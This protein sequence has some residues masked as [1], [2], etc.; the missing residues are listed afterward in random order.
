MP[1]T[2]AQCRRRRRRLLA[3]LGSQYKAIDAHIA[4]EQATWTRAIKNGW[5]A[6]AL[7]AVD[8]LKVLWAI[9]DAT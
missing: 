3:G 1:A 8:H 6:T 5:F 9:S 7:A 2:V 4:A